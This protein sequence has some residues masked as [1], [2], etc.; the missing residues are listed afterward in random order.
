M[1][2]VSGLHVAAL[3]LVIAALLAAVLRAVPVSLPSI[4]AR[5]AAALAAL[6]LVWG[7]VVF[8]GNQPP[9]VRSALMLSVVLLG[10]RCGDPPMR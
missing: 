3:A 2:S 5:R 7:Y 8:T 1:L 4:D 9:A 10:A 6:P